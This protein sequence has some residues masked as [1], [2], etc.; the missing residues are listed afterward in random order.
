LALEVLAEEIR[1]AKGFEEG[2]EGRLYTSKI[3]VPPRRSAVISST[4]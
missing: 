2:H 4:V 3:S 1:V